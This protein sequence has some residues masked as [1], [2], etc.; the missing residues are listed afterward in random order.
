MFFDNGT[1]EN[2]VLQELVAKASTEEVTVENENYKFTVLSHLYSKEQQMGM[3]ICSF[4]F[5]TEE[6]CGL[7][8]NDVQKVLWELRSWKIRWVF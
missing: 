5:L 3:I 2:G 8:V 7:M 1:E 6:D 4:R